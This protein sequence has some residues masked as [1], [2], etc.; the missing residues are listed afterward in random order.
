MKKCDA[1][2]NAIQSESKVKKNPPPLFIVAS[3]RSG[4]N[5]LRKRITDNQEIYFSGTPAHFFKHLYYTQ[6]YYGKL[7]NDSVFKQVIDDAIDLCTR[8]FSPWDVHFQTDQIF[9]EY[10]S[11]YDERNI[12]F[13]A[14]L[15]MTK[16]AKERGYESYIC[17]DNNLFDFLYQI[18]FFLGESR[19]IYLYRDPRDVV[20]S[21]SKR[22]YRHNIIQLAKRWSSEQR[23]CFQLYSHVFRERTFFLSYEQFIQNEEEVIENILRFL[24]V[25]RTQGK[26]RLDLKSDIPEWKNLEKETIPDNQKKYRTEFTEAQNAIIEKI[27]MEEMTLLGYEPEFE[28]QFKL[29]HYYYYAYKARIVDKLLRLGIIKEKEVTNSYKDRMEFIETFKHV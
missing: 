11:T 18:I 17:K 16:Y 10:D 27:C 4:T 24:S 1:N 20:L 22:I 23:R 3:E 26:K 25:K 8:H 5:L 13:L 6:P 21:E 14:H 9:E 2:K 12:F 15:M 19:F 7:D 29:R 28:K